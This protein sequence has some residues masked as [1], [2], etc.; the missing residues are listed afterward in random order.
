MRLQAKQCHRAPRHR[1]L[2]ILI[3]SVRYRQPV[4]RAA[5]SSGGRPPFRPTR[6]SGEL[7]SHSGTEA[8]LRGQCRVEQWLGAPRPR[9]RKF[10]F[11]VAQEPEVPPWIIDLD[12]RSRVLRGGR[13]F[14]VIPSAR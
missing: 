2:M 1:G 13:C 4:I 9:P 12:P 10:A 5:R 6:E 11:R 14:C 8:H 7:A 3:H